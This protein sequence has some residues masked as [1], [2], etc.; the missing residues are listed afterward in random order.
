MLHQIKRAVEPTLL[1]REVVADWNAIAF[2]LAEHH[3]RR[4]NQVHDTFNRM[5]TS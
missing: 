3:R 4:M 5:Q 1:L 2:T